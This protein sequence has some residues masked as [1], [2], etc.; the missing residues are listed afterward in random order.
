MSEQLLIVLA[1]SVSGTLLLA[2]EVLVMPGFGVA[3]ILGLLALATAAGSSILFLGWSSGGLTVVA[4]ALVT[5]TL[6][7]IGARRASRRRRNAEDPR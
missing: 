5:G 6:V 4:L 2:F 7:R 1:L 3:G